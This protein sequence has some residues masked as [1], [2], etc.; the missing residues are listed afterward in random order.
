MKNINSNKKLSESFIKKLAE[1]SAGYLKNSDFE[2]LISLFEQEISEKYFTESSEANLLRIILNTYDKISFLNE[3][4]I[5]PHYAEILVSISVYSNYLTD[6]LVRNPEFFYWIVNPST[7]KTKYDLDSFKVEVESAI[8]SFKSF[9]AKTNAL[10]TIKRKH[11]LKIGIKDIFEKTDLEEI[12]KSLSIIAKG[13]SSTLFEMCYQSVQNKYELENLK[14]NYSVVSLGKLGGNELNYSSDIDLIVFYDED[15]E[16]KNNFKYSEFLNEAILLFI[17]SISSITSAGF[18]YRVDFRLRPFGKNSSLTG[19]ITEYLNYYES[20][21]E[22]WERQMLIKMNFLC[23]DFDLYTKFKNYLNPFI[24]PSSF[25]ISPTEQIKKLKKNI[26]RKLK[27]NENI[28][29]ASGG[30]RDIEFSVQALQLLNGGKINEIKTPN[31]IDAIEKLKRHKLLSEKETETFLNAYNFYRK[32]EHF[33]QLMNDT[34]THSI[35]AEGETLE[36]LSSFLNFKTSADFQNKVKKYRKEVSRVFNEITGTKNEL[37]K[38]KFDLQ[39]INFQNYQKAIRDLEFLSEGKGILEQKQF[40]KKSINEFSKIEETLFN[41]LKKSVDPNLVLQNFV[42]FIRGVEFPSIW[43]QEFSNKKFFNSF[44]KICEYSQYTIDL[45][46]EDEE[47]IEFLLSKKVLEKL[48]KNKII[49]FTLKKLLFVLSI[50]FTLELIDHS[51]VSLLLS[52]FIKNKIE[53]ISNECLSEKIIY[54]IAGLGSFGINEMTFYSDVD[55]IF[56]VNKVDTNQNIQKEFQSLLLKLKDELKP[57]QVDCRLRPE[58]KSSYLVWELNS[59]KKY[60]WERA[61]IW[62]LQAY[63]KINF[64]C[65]NKKSYNSLMKSFSERIKK[66][67]NDKIKSEFISMRKNLYPHDFSTIGRSFNIKK[68]I[69]GLNDI[70]FILQ[71]LVLTNHKIFNK[72][73]GKGSE[74]I[75]NE[76]KKINSDFDNL[77]VLNNYFNFMK[78]LELSNQLVFNSSKKTIPI[79]KE[80]KKLL[81]KKLGFD[82]TGLFDSYLLDL[83][84]KIHSNYKTYLGS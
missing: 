1:I 11:I 2:N 30:I 81:S 34:Q 24:Y 29:L 14:N 25:S 32:T 71:Y 8:K 28:K 74:K 60:F 73:I 3:C 63:S 77:L 50:Q 79:T 9:N 44:L 22:D 39:S 21:G 36:K 42:R 43:Y 31:T 80:K 18:I 69:G 20:F 40:D 23:G 7:L 70:E 6:I 55:L 45:F 68:S 53:L 17:E 33:L 12:T 49:N 76:L 52:E 38:D 41:Y 78:T 5:Y 72:C 48:N 57:F 35:P 84:N 65:G 75:I 83:I 47:L 13:I 59:Y 51:K 37:S 54:F 15:S 16:L 62:E 66:E 27:S 58:G 67:D 64:I 10:R 19:S 4:L 56:A 26:E 61:R 46:A 82:S